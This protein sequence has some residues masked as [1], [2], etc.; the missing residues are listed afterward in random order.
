MQTLLSWVKL[1]GYSNIEVPQVKKIN[2]II[3]YLGIV[4]SKTLSLENISS[5]IT[6]LVES[7]L[8]I[9]QYK[10]IENF[11]ENL[12][13][14]LERLKLMKSPILIKSDKIYSIL[15]I[16]LTNEIPKLLILNHIYE[17]NNNLV[18]IIKSSVCRWFNLNEF[19]L[20]NNNDMLIEILLLNI[21]NQI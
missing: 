2:D 7:K 8:E 12:S 3:T 4:N 13:M 9:L 14:L 15:G 10:N 1:N 11:H 18:S 17:S 5:I 20:E 6:Y 19:I 16:D 21:E